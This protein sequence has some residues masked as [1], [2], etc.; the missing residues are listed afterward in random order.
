MAVCGMC[1]PLLILLIDRFSFLKQTALYQL[2]ILSQILDSACQEVWIVD[3]GQPQAGEVPF[4]Q[5]FH[6]M[7]L[8]LWNY[9]QKVALKV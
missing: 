7:R 8:C 4:S 6:C 2:Q 1:N 9:Y 3:R 5:L